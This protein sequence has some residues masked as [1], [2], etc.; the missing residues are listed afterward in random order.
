MTHK[1]HTHTH[2]THTTHTQHTHTHTQHTQHTHTHTHTQYLGEVDEALA[3]VVRAIA[4]EIAGKS[5]EVLA[6]LGL[7]AQNV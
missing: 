7:A 6:V 1:T 2:N 4:L 3:E 5:K